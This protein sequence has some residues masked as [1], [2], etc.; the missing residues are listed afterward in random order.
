MHT[1]I[2]LPTAAVATRVIDIWYIE[3]T[4]VFGREKSLRGKG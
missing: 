2:K 3:F 4:S 1:A